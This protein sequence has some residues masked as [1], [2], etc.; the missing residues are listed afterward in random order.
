[1]AHGPNIMNIYSS[2]SLVVTN[3][4]P[5]QPKE[6]NKHETQK[7]TQLFPGFPSI[8]QKKQHETHHV[9]QPTC[10]NWLWIL[11]KSSALNSAPQKNTKEMSLKR[12]YPRN[13]LK[14]MEGILKIWGFRWKWFSISIGWFALVPAVV[15]VVVVVA[16]VSRV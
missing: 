4:I 13:L 6:K 12:K 16:I 10:S 11:A 15:V 14:Q 7:S 5:P 2:S 1:M 3:V 9:F 8:S